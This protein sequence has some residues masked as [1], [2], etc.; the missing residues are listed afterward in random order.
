MGMTVGSCGCGPAMATDKP[1]QIKHQNAIAPRKRSVLISCAPLLFGAK[2][3]AFWYG[4]VTL[5]LPCARPQPSSS[6]NAYFA[7]SA[8]VPVNKKIVLRIAVTQLVVFLQLSPSFGSSGAN[9]PAP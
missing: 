5:C 7:E 1:T 6:V 2:L 3:R 9:F 4:T 8:A